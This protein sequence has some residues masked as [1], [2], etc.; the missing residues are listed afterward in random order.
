LDFG[1]I[2]FIKLTLAKS[3]YDKNKACKIIQSDQSFIKLNRPQFTFQRY[4]N[5]S[6]KLFK[7]Q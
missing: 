1:Y 5:L 3:K 2:R 4:F 7:P 6:Q